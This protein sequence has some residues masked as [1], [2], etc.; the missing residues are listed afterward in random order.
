MLSNK[1]IRARAREALG[2][3]VF[4]NEWL[5]ALAV[6]LVVDAISGALSATFVGGILIAGFVNCGKT[7]Y[8]SA[9]VRREVPYDRL[10]VT[11]DTV[12]KNPSDIFITGILHTL[13]ILLW[14]LLF[15]VPGIVKSLSY[16][17]TFYIRNDRPELT[18]EEAITESRRMMDGYKWKYFL[19]ELSFIGWMV[20][21]VICCGIGV[22]WVGA[23]MEAARAVFYEELKANRRDCIQ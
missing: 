8:F 3:G 23:Y 11:V 1:E 18:A 22:M 13:F 7:G 12:K 17:M 19:L 2:G 6:V 16:A 20:V 4:K 9:I 21:G 14:T 15:F 5:Y 10:G